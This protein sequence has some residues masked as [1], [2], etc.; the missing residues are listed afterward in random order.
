MEQTISRAWV[1][2]TNADIGSGPRRKMPE[3][4]AQLVLASRGSTICF[5]CKRRKKLGL[6]VCWRCYDEGRP[7]PTIVESPYDTDEI[8]QE[9]NL[10][11]ELFRTP[12]SRW[13]NAFAGWISIRVQTK[14]DDKDAMYADLRY[15]PRDVFSN[16]F[17]INS[18]RSES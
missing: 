13:K 9:R 7:A 5:G 15:A 10:R 14:D 17:V 3:T 16:R 2:Q 11:E 4:S 12:L 1:T 6:V 8:I 18:T